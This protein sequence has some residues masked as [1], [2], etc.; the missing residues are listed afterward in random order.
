MTEI[1][2]P[3][4]REFGFVQGRFVEGIADLLG[5]GD[6]FPDLRAIVGSGTFTPA[7]AIRLAS[8]TTP[9]TVVRRKIECP[10]NDQGWIVD[11]ESEAD[12]EKK[13]GVW[14]A[15]GRWTFSTSFSA[16][17]PIPSYTIEVTTEHTEENP[18]DLTLAAPIVLPPNSVEIVRVIDRVLA[19]ESAG[20]AQGYAETASEAASTAT[21]ASSSASDSAAAALASQEATE[22]LGITVDTSAGTRVS[23]GN[24]VV[25]YNSGW[26]KISGE[27]PNWAWINPQSSM[28]PDEGV[29]VRR[30]LDTI[31]VRVV[32]TVRTAESANLKGEIVWGIPETFYPRFPEGSG[33]DDVPIAAVIGRPGAETTFIYSRR[34]SPGRVWVDRMVPIGTKVNFVATIPIET[35]L[36]TTLPGTPA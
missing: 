30:L 24:T 8:G 23:V 19:Q 5:D 16:A 13:P 18:L 31:Q 33:Q 27:V 1:I 7:R 35:G 26:R 12:P 6:R 34:S 36:P 14:L 15:V 20:E 25:Y 4:D 17:T 10:L 21:S 11:P 22:A 28:E 9:A 29:W 3:P 2:D 32:G